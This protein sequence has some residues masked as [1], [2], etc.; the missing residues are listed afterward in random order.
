MANVAEMVDA[1]GGVEVIVNESFVSDRQ[2]T[3]PVGT[4][5]LDGRL[6]LEFVRTY[7]PGGD[8]QRLQ[9]QN[10]FL[11]GLQK[12]GTSL[13]IV[14]HAPALIKQ[15]EKVVVTDLTPRQLL[16][17]A[18]IVDQVPIERIGMFNVNP[19]MLTR[20]TSASE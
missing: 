15:F 7:E 19:T 4:R 2:V 3:Y 12:Q 1:L 5:Q 8:P 10:Q 16:D 14:T 13:G 9:H 17:L 6:A 11:W 18:C 20:A